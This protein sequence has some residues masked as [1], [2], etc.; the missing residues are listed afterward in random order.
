MINDQHG[1]AECVYMHVSTAA[2]F[3]AYDCFDGFT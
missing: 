2:C 3:S 1:T